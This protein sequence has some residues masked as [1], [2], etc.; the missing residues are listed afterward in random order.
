MYNA[1]T[2]SAIT[3]LS[4]ASSVISKIKNIKNIKNIKQY[5]KYQEYLKYR[6]YQR[7]HCGASCSLNGVYC[8]DRWPTSGAFT[9]WEILMVMVTMMVMMKESLPAR[10]IS[11]LLGLSQQL[12]HY[13]S[14]DSN[15]EKKQLRAQGEIFINTIH[16]STFLGAFE[17]VN[18]I[19]RAALWGVF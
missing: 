11:C 2:H 12:T 9:H 6:K 13:N 1:H 15:E 18:Y 19:G 4:P 10:I 16:I 14:W 8:D 3:N 5:K 7:Y 17:I